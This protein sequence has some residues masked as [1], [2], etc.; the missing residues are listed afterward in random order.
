VIVP[1]KPSQPGL[2][3]AVKPRSLLHKVAPE[4]WAAQAG[5]C[6]IGRYKTKLGSLARNKRS[7]LFSLFVGDEENKIF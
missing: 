4:S 6:L 7:C 1:G 3:F 2:I 5:Y